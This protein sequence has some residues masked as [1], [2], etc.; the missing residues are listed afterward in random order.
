MLQCGHKNCMAS[1]HY[2]VLNEAKFMKNVLKQNGI[3]CFLEGY[4]HRSILYFFGPYVEISL[5]V[6]RDR[7]SEASNIIAEL[8][9]E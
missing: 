3:P 1:P 9:D 5:F 6:Q 7:E 8:S 4:Y 2:P